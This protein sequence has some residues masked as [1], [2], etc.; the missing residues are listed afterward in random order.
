MAPGN[1]VSGGGGSNNPA[2]QP[3]S[4]LANLANNPGLQ[5]QMGKLVQQQQQQQNVAV[6]VHQSTQPHQAMGVGNQQVLLSCIMNLVTRKFAVR[7]NS[8]NLDTFLWNHYD[9][10]MSIEERLICSITLLEYI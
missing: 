1:P 10:R 7:Y 8:I 6:S 4:Q 5:N 9:S 3:L 2:E